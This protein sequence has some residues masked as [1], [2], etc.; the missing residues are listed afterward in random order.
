LS[1]CQLRKSIYKRSFSISK[2]ASFGVRVCWHESGQKERTQAQGV[3]LGSWPAFA[4][5][6]ALDEGVLA[7]VRAKGTHMLPAACCALHLAE[8]SESVLMDLP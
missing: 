2:R 4:G 8:P 6:G 3:V 1:F 5:G 7:W